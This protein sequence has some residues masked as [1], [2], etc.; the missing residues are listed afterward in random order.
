MT[1]LAAAHPLFHMRWSEGELGRPGDNLYQ[2]SFIAARPHKLL[3]ELDEQVLLV[4]TEPRLLDSFDAQ[5]RIEFAQM[6]LDWQG[7]ED[8]TPHAST[9]LAGHLVLAKH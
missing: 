5:V 6:V 4:L 3:I 7:Y 2:L 1:A 8:M 9:W